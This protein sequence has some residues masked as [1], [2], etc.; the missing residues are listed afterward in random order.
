M[1]TNQKL[2]SDIYMQ[3]SVQ[4]YAFTHIKKRLLIPAIDKDKIKQ[5]QM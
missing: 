3:L 1:Q 5:G 4:P 2:N